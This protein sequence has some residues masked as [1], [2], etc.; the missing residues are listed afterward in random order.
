MDVDQAQRD[1]HLEKTLKKYKRK[2]F[3]FP[4]RQILSI[5]SIFM[6]RNNRG[7][8][9]INTFKIE[10][11]YMWHSGEID[12]TKRFFLAPILLVSIIIFYH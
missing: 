2:V 7:V 8:Q 12:T 3:S 4:I 9:L 1:K 11:P 6:I 10:L 5:I